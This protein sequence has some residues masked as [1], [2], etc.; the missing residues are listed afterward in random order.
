MFCP[1]CGTHMADNAKFCPS[2]GAKIVCAEAP[3][4]AGAQGEPA[5]MRAATA[6]SSSSSAQAPSDAA[7]VAAPPRRRRIA[8]YVV[9]GVAV[10]A[11]C[12]AVV[13]AVRG[14]SVPSGSGDDGLFSSPAP[15][16][17]LEFESG[18]VVSDGTYDYYYSVDRAG[19]VRAAIDGSG[20]EVVHPLDVGLNASVFRIGNFCL[21][22]D[23]LYYYQF[24]LR[25]NSNRLGKPL[26]DDLYEVHRLAT[27]GSSDEVIYTVNGDQYDNDGDMVDLLEVLA[28]DGTVYAVVETT[29]ES[30]KGEES[31]VLRMDADGGNVEEIASLWNQDGCSIGLKPD[32]MYYL[33]GKRLIE[34]EET[35]YPELYVQNLDGSGLKRLYVSSV[36]SM[37][38]PFMLGD[39]LYAYEWNQ[40][41]SM[42]RLISMD[43]NGEN[44]RV[45]LDV[46]ALEASVEEQAASEMGE[47]APGAE[48]SVS[49]RWIDG[50][51]IMLMLRG[52]VREQRED[53]SS[54][55]RYLLR[56]LSAAIDGRGDVEELFTIE[57][58]RPDGGIMYGISRVGDH[59]VLSESTTFD[60]DDKPDAYLVDNKGNVMAYE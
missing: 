22:G 11:V 18:A 53:G 17:G 39:R 35:I 1:Q 49:H 20:V 21:D 8:R 41:T 56:A 23:Y 50:S 5:H 51:R 54:A 12:V 45:E 24:Y 44:V 29:R 47:S 32:R 42:T 26:E 19:I 52:T 31:Q 57:D 28:Y 33:T 48:W 2:C 7:P 6:P 13:L 16:Q 27:D 58:V 3:A 14:V 30:P 36:G 34:E 40:D 46:S 37:S 59:F 55:E 9:A 15:Q 10:L 38:V 43:E 25:T 60:A 4:S